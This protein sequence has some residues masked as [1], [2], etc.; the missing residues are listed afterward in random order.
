MKKKQSK[1]CD[2]FE[3][4]EETLLLNSW[5]PENGTERLSLI[6]EDIRQIM[7]EL[8]ES[9][10]A[11]GES[12]EKSIKEKRKLLLAIIGVKDAFENVFSNINKKKEFVTGKTKIWV[13]NFRTVYRLLDAILLKQGVVKIDNTDGDFDP[14]WH[15]IVD[16]AKDPSKFDGT[17]VKELRTGYVWQKQVLR[18]TEVVVINNSAEDAESFENE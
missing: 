18:E 13:G 11:S 8:A 14:Q 16:I 15:K 1:T 5:E 4:K 12:T 6:E 9:E 10:F 7:L 3:I 2:L 17:I